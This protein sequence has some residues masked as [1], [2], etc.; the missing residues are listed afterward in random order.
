MSDRFAVA[1][2]DEITPKR[3]S[4]GIT[5]RGFVDESGGQVSV[6]LLQVENAITHHHRVTTELYVILDGDGEMELDGSGIRPGR[7]PR[8]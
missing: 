8:S 3:C 7:C 2:L 5:R 4:C 1:Q 6:H